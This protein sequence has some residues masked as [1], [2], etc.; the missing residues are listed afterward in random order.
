VSDMRISTR[1][2]RL[3]SIRVP[4][5]QEDLTPRQQARLRRAL[6]RE[7]SQHRKPKPRE[8]VEEYIRVVIGYAPILS[9]LSREPKAAE[10]RK[11]LENV[12]KA[13]DGLT[14]ALA[15]LCSER[16]AMDRFNREAEF[17]HRFGSTTTRSA[18]NQL[19]GLAAELCEPPLRADMALERGGAT[20]ML[21]RLWAYVAAASLIA[22]SARSKVETSR[23]NRHEDQ[24]TIHLLRYLEHN[25]FIIFKDSPSTRRGGPFDRV[26]QAVGTVLGIKIGGR[27]VQR[28]HP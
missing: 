14:A 13:A 16:G 26:A 8:Q 1:P 23:G 3:N 19:K 10:T 4:R 22:E 18:L 6:L 5:E 15:S 17:I 20:L 11:Q 28:R 12:R 21:Q 2:A 9:Y 25:W 24:Q 27:L 7:F